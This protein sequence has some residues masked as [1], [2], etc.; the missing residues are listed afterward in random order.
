MEEKREVDK[1][2]WIERVYFTYLIDDA[3]RSACSAGEDEYE[4]HF[5]LEREW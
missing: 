5:T 1:S 3:R 4:H 2:E